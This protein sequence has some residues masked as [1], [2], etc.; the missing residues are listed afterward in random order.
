MKRSSSEFWLDGDDDENA[1]LFLALAF[2]LSLFHTT[3]RHS[4]VEVK[5][6]ERLGELLF[7]FF[8]RRADKGDAIAAGCHRCRRRRQRF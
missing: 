2:P 3:H 7:F 4:V 5:L 6:R 1:S 8:V